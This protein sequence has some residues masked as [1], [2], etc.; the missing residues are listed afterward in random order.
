MTLN[1]LAVQEV[2]YASTAS[3]TIREPPTPTLPFSATEPKLYDAPLRNHW[4]RFT[5]ERRRAKPAY[6]TSWPPKCPPSGD[7]RNA[8]PCE[9]DSPKTR[10]QQSK[11]L[12]EAL[13]CGL[14]RRAI[15]TFSERFAKDAPLM[16]LGLDVGDE[17]AWFWR[18]AR[19]K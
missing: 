16:K 4:T 7:R 3:A 2:A 18:R 14:P 9:Y 13:L 11:I 10:V 17:Y 5:R 8:S 15:L 1:I 12:E 6:P 19:R